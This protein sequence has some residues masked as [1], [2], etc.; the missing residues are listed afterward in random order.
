MLTP[1]KTTLRIS[2]SLSIIAILVIALLTS[3]GMQ[4]NAA[5]QNTV[6]QEQIRGRFARAFESIEEGNIRTDLFAEASQTPSGEIV[7][8]LSVSKIDT[9]TDTFVFGFFGFGPADQLTVANDQSSATFSGTV[10][11]IEDITGEEMTFTVDVDLTATGKPERFGFKDRFIT[12][13]F[14]ALTIVNGK[15]RPASGSMDV[16]GEGMTFS[17]D[18]ASGEIGRELRGLLT[19]TKF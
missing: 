9:S 7:I 13:D 12:P 5:A 15:V 11:A 17:T 2:S 8:I 19:V 14:K 6:F 1:R 4:T 18:D 3:V 10:T 16:S